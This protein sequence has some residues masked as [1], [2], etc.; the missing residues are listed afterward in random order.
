[1]TAHQ[2]EKGMKIQRSLA[3]IDMYQAH[4]D[5]TRIDYNSDVGKDA[6]FVMQDFLQKKK[7]VL[8]KELDD[9]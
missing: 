6:W 4:S 5:Y 3:E 9:L 8:L 7:T 1:M 2:L